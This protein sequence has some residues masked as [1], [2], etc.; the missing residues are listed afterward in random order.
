MS[1]DAWN[2]SPVPVFA[3]SDETGVYGPGHN[4]FSVDE[5]GRDVLVFHGRDD[6]TIQG[7]PLFDPNRHTRVQRLYYHPDGTPDFG[8]PVGAGEIPDRFA[9]VDRPGAYPAPGWRAAG[10][11]RRR[12]GDHA[13]SSEGWSD[14]RGVAGAGAAAWPGPGLVARRRDRAGARGRWIQP[15]IQ[16]GAAFGRFAAWRAVVGCRSRP[17]LRRRV[18]CV[19]P[20]G[21]VVVEP[22]E[23][24]A[25]R[26]SATFVV[27]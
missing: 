16:R 15:R 24:A 25:G 7:N 6:K 10:G 26:A 14:R 5:Q 1:P 17:W 27:S 23:D 21:A 9:P 11:R 18:I 2:K 20:D 4:S 8:V 13:V 3:S 19:T 22:V 12:P